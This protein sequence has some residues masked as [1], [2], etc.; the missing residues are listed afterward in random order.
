VTSVSDQA[1]DDLLRGF[2]H[3]AVHLETRDA[4]GTAVELPHMAKWAAGEP[5]DLDWLQDW[6]ETLR[7]HVRAGRSVRRLHIVN[8]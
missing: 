8:V 2:H 6:C 5:D 3:E 4:Y 1:F 7:T